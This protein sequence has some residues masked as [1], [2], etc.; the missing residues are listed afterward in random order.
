[1]KED[2]TEWTMNGPLGI[3]NSADNKPRK[4]KSSMN[5]RPKYE[6][7]IRIDGNASRESNRVNTNSNTEVVEASS[8]SIENSFSKRIM[9]SKIMKQ[10]DTF[11]T[12][13]RIW[14]VRK[15][16]K[17]LVT[18]TT[19]RLVVIGLIF[20]NAIL[21]GIGT[22]IPKESKEYS[23]IE[24]I[25]KTFL[26]VFTIELLIQFTAYLLR[27]FLDGWLVFDFLIIV[28]GWTPDT[29]GV[30]VFRVFRI[31]RALRLIT[32]V[33]TMKQL[34]SAIFSVLPSIAAILMLLLLIFYIFAVML[35]QLFEGSKESE[36]YFGNLG[37]TLFTLFQIMTFDGWGG[38]VYETTTASDF[39]YVKGIIIVFLFITGFIVLNLVIAV[40]C[41][42]VSNA[43][44]DVKGKMH[45]SFDEDDDDVE[46]EETMKLV[47]ERMLGVEEQLD[48]LEQVLE[49]NIHTLEYLT[50]ELKRENLNLTE[51][52]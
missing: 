52:S 49:R 36:D 4:S 33:K 47:R 51:Q 1:M 26:I 41:D 15:F 8:A 3:S 2:N 34:V 42:A 10:V 28:V 21:I 46:S 24:A 20:T 6:A 14:E 9:D 45:G 39:V 27:L 7:A 11:F 19:F 13:G 38:V 22:Y 48:S 31:F 29:G 50:R 5:N 35:T 12:T 37:I 23:I 32:R 40:I 16:C 43:G 17:M 30:T 18:N 25:D 44:D